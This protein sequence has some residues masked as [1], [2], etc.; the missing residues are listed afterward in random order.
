MKLAHFAVA[1]LT[2]S[3]LAVMPAVAQTL[4]GPIDVIDN[5][6]YFTQKQ[7]D[8]GGIALS[9]NG[10]MLVVFVK[11]T[12]TQPQTITSVKLNGTELDT[13]VGNGTLEYWRTWPLTIQPGDIAHIQM[14]ANGSPLN[15]GQTATVY[16]ETNLG[17]SDQDSVVLSAPRIRLGNCFLSQDRQTFYL[18]IRNLDTVSYSIDNVYLDDEVTNNCTFV[19]GSSTIPGESVG[20]VKIAMG[21]PVPVMEHYALRIRTTKSGGGTVWNGSW[22]RAIQPATLIGTWSGSMLDDSDSKEHGRQFFHSMC[23]GHFN[24]HTGAWPGGNLCRAY[25]QNSIRSHTIINYEPTPGAEKVPHEPTIIE[26]EGKPSI[27]GYMVRDEPAI[28]GKPSQRMADHNQIY[29]QNDVTKPTLINLADDDT[30]VEYLNIVDIS[31]QDHYAHNAPLTGPGGLSNSILWQERSKWAAEPRFSYCWSQTGADPFGSQKP[32]V[33]SVCCQFWGNIAAGSKG[34][35]WFKYGPGYETDSDYAANMAESKRLGL[36]FAQI[37]SLC[38]YAESIDNVVSTNSDIVSHALIGENRMVV[39]AVNCNDYS[40]GWPWDKQWHLD[41]ASGTVTATVPSWININN[42]Y[43][44]TDAGQQ[45]VSPSINGREISFNVSLDGDSGSDWVAVY[46]IGDSDTQAPEAPTGLNV[47]E[48]ETSSKY[49]LSWNVPFDDIGVRGY[50]VYRNGVEIADTLSPV[51]ADTS[52]TASATYYVKAYD[53]AGN[54]GPASHTIQLTQPDWQFD[55]D[56]DYEG[57]AFT[58]NVGGP[59]PI[60]VE[61]GILDCDSDGNDP[62]IHSPNILVDS[63]VNKYVVVGMK[64]GTSSNIAQIF[65]ITDLDQ[66]W[67]SNKSAAVSIVPN[68]TVIREYVFDLTANAYWANT[69]T[70]IR[71][72]P[73][74]TS[75][76]IDIDYIYLTNS[77]GPT[78]TFTETPTATDTPT[79]TSTPTNTEVGQPTNTFTPTATNTNTPTVTATATNTPTATITNTPTATP[80]SKGS[81]GSAPMYRTPEQASDASATTSA[82]RALLPLLPGLLAIGAWVLRRRYM[83]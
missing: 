57:W 55:V 46:V 79:A 2:L 26:A 3:A 71:L 44:L 83:M 68:D 6:M 49:I 80:T 34:V 47:C 17:N 1:L 11:N 77:V 43:E 12:D 42:Y 58:N 33:F 62:F 32:P 41:A 8:R 4:G 28:N 65:W 38:L 72:D 22:I 20:I 40:S 14:F 24:G 53:S 54:L 73:V 18:Y 51:F 23:G 76:D 63:S 37:N 66:V 82:T 81:C 67:E 75:G 16:V 9:S 10:G 74:T 7:M 19:G 35:S 30:M 61:N 69:I 21:S 48:V 5:G 13:L 52:A 78:P 50:K 31:M 45:S 59:N 15:A 64:N 60:T 70:Q 36:W 27:W 29:W 39:I 56:T 25:A